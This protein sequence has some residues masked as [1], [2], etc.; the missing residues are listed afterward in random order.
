MLN[1]YKFVVRK[2]TSF[3]N[4]KQEF[5]MKWLII[6]PLIVMSVFSQAAVERVGIDVERGQLN[7]EVSMERQFV[8]KDLD[9]GITDNKTPIK[10]LSSYYY[11][12][13]R[14]DIQALKDLHY[15]GD[16]TLDHLNEELSE[17]PDKFEGFSEL[18]RVSLGKIYIWENYYAVDVVW[19]T[20]NQ[21]DIKWTDL[22]VCNSKCY[23]SYKPYMESDQFDFFANILRLLKRYPSVSSPSVFKGAS[24]LCIDKS[25]CANPIKVAANFK[26]SSLKS[27]L[28]EMADFNAVSKNYPKLISLTTMLKA[29]KKNSPIFDSYL[30]KEVH[31]KKLFGCCW[32]EAGENDQIKLFDMQLLQSKIG[33]Y[34]VSYYSPIMLFDFLKDVEYAHLHGV[35]TTDETEFAFAKIKHIEYERPALQMFTFSGRKDP[36]SWRLT[37]APSNQT[38]KNV[39]TYHE[40]ASYIDRYLSSD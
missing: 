30:E 29:A 24:E 10:L 20:K 11:H 3:Q 6:L 15:A 33:Q 35:L 18:S 26:K 7:F 37:S 2:G 31:I 25:G 32:L 17:M 4:H 5:F 14:N 21:G 28:V 1:R 22:L 34:K 9:L 16:G 13:I 12:G 39:L 40:V 36:S 19:H 27:N 23:I 8:G 38:L